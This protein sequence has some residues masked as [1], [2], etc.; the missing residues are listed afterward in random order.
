MQVVEWDLTAE[1]KFV[2][3][4]WNLSAEVDGRPTLAVPTDVILRSY[5][6]GMDLSGSEQGAGGVGGLLFESNAA[7]ATWHPTYDGNGN[8]TGLRDANGVP[9]GTY[10][11]G[12][13]GETLFAWGEAALS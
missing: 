4:G 9:A 3:D 13:F 1:T 12:P 6:W 10:E 5:A 7:G 8:V 11:Y 2:W